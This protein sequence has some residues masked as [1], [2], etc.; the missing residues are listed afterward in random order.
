LK[1]KTFELV[2]Y[3]IKKVADFFKIKMASYEKKRVHKIP[4][5]RRERLFPTFV[6]SV[7]VRK[8]IN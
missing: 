5:R 8:G 6:L 1:N 3:E 7:K 2:V 4:F